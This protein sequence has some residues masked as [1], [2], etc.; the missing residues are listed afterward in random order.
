MPT[1][2]IIL[3]AVPTAVASARARRLAD[4]ELAGGPSGRGWGGANANDCALGVYAEH[5]NPFGFRVTVRSWAPGATISWL[6][7]QNV[8]R[9]HFWGPV[10][11]RRKHNGTSVLSFTLQAAPK[12]RRGGS[13]RR[14]DQWGFVLAERYRGTWQVLCTLPNPPPAPPRAPV[15]AA[16][17]VGAGK[18]PSKVGTDGGALV[19]IF[20]ALAGSVSAAVGWLTAG[21]PT[22]SGTA[23]QS[24]S[25][26]HGDKRKD[27]RA[28]R[29]RR[30][31]GRA[32]GK[33]AGRGR[34]K[35]DQESQK[36]RR[37][38]LRSRS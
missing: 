9:T 37:G 28:N 13:S 19:G 29:A 24:R 31:H 33:R 11:G 35:R 3:F 34:R 25:A 30:G 20:S 2:V 1:R 12:P 38:M 14:T 17:P 18:G 15:H 8:T 4:N 22:T 16:V 7:E 23:A 6:F 10:A 32:A 36:D 21:T 27:K 26:R 5:P